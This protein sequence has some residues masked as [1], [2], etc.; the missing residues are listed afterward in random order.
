M[1]QKGNSAT[2]LK[3]GKMT[4]KTDANEKRGKTI[5]QD[6]QFQSTKIANSEK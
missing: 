1:K 6:K 4:S 5:L 3:R 2:T